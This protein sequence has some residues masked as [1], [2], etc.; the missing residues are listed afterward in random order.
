VCLLTF[1]EEKNSIGVKGL[2]MV[3]TGPNYF[4]QLRIIKYKVA[5]KDGFISGT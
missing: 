3:I 5:S 4:S 2:T 1:Y